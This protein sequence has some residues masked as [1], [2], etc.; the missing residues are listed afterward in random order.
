MNLRR[1]IHLAPLAAV[2]AMLAGQSALAE[3]P[4]G[5]D[6]VAFQERSVTVRF[7]DLDLSREAGQQALEARLEMATRKVCRLD[8]RR[9][10][11]QRMLMQRCEQ[12]AMSGAMAQLDDAVEPRLIAGSGPLQPRVSAVDDDH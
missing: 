3:A 7:D 11:R 4:Q 5:L 9:S 1:S 6:A 10:A 8:N 12:Q 2:L